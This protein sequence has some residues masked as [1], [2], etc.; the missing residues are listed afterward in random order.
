[1][2]MAPSV[3]SAILEALSLDPAAT[4]I[5]SHGGS[6]FASTFKISSTTDGKEKNYFVKTGS[7]SDSELM[8]KGM[9][10]SVRNSRSS[11]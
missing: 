8:F 1:V 6:G 5:G 3:D 10:L 4:K 7:G 9:D 2:I 11:R